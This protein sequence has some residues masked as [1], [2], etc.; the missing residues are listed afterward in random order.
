M[1]TP[2]SFALRI[3]GRITSSTCR[4]TPN[5]VPLVELEIADYASGQTVC[6]THR[7]ADTGP[8]SCMA[9]T[10]LAHSLRGQH[11]E[12]QAINPRFKAQRLECD[13]DLIHPTHTGATRR[14]LA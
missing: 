12:L 10:A 2:T 13:A 9:A 14:D 4:F 5:G 6:I 8:A 3:S 7:Y 11:A 1:P